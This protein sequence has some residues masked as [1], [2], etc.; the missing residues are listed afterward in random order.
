MASNIKN[1]VQNNKASKTHCPKEKKLIQLLTDLDISVDISIPLVEDILDKHP[2][3]STLDLLTKIIDQLDIKKTKKEKPKTK[4]IKPEEW[5][6][7]PSDDLRFIYSESNGKDIY[8][9]FRNKG[10]ILDFDQL[11][12]EGTS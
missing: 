11:I 7:L 3:M 5:K 6:S 8:N 12:Q 2:N 9:A 1:S 10:V 4:F